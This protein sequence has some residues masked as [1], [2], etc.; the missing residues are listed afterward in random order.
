MFKYFLI[1][2]V[3]INEFHAIERRFSIVIVLRFGQVVVSAGPKYCSSDA[4]SLLRRLWL[5]KSTKW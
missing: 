4:Q 2:L 3:L 1:S 5:V